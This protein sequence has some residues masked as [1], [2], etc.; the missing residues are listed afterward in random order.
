MPGAFK[1]DHLQ[2]IEP[3]LF[4]TF[5]IFFTFIL[6]SHF[7]LTQRANNGKVR[8]TQLNNWM[9]QMD[10][11]AWGIQTGPFAVHWAHFIL[12]IFHLFTFILGS[13]FLLPQRANYG[14]LRFTQLK[15]W[16][17]QMDF[18]AWGIQT[19]PFAVHWAH[20]VLTISIFFNKGKSGIHPTS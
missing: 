15:N 13:H 2:S 12:K 18:N 11:N 3:I 14:K 17:R 19:G 7:L 5:S 10:F 20:F 1:L 8:F 4:W 6:G 9:T 16:I